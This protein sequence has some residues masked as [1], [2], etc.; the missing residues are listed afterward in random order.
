LIRNYFNYLC[1]FKLWDPRRKGFI[2]DYKEHNGAINALKFSP[3]GRY[4]ITA[5]DDTAIRVRELD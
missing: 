1:L 3:D 5:S 2:F 4:L